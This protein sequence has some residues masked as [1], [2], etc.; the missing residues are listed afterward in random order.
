MGVDERTE[1]EGP[2]YR[3][4]VPASWTV[5]RVGRRGPATDVIEARGERVPLSVYAAV[6]PPPLPGDEV[7]DLVIGGIISDYRNH[8]HFREIGYG[9]GPVEGSDDG[10]MAELVIGKNVPSHVLMRSARLR[11]GDV[12]TVQAAY[13]EGLDD[14]HPQAVELVDSLVVTS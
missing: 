2:G 12:V 6:Q 7:A 8:P 1:I 11:N 13:P 14:L 3:L 5:E 4:T 10:W 9:H